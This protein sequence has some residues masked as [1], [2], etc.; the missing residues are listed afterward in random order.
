MANDIGL[1]CV[2]EGVE[3][4]EQAEL[5]KSSECRIIQGFYFDRPLP[6]N[7]FETRLAN[8]TYKKD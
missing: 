5:V 2:A 1:Q 3:T 4:K 7:E 8:Y 6:V